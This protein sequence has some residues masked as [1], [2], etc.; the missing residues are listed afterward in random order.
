MSAGRFSPAIAVAAALLLGSVA[1]AQASDIR[2]E[3]VQFAAGSTGTSIEGS[4]S[5]Y[6]IVDYRLG[7]QSG[8][9][10]V[11]T[12][13]TDSGAN[14]FNLMAPGETEVAFFNGSMGEN[15]FVGSL[16]DSGDY[17]IRVYQMR[18]AAR[19]NETASYT[20]QIEI[21]S[22][23]S[24]GASSGAVADATVPGTKYHATG[25]IPCARAAG[26]P[27]GQCEF[28]VIREGQ[29]SGTL[30]VSWPE[31]GK[32]VIFYE[33]GTPMSFDSSEADGGVEMAVGKESDL[34]QVRIGEER[35]EIPD[36]VFLGDNP[37]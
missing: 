28:G 24:A 35:F 29:G 7:A 36:V 21:T 4:I 22:P 26:Q 1:F 25:S 31:G 10:M 12:M 17:T 14:Y 18:S 33:D 16:P 5:G 37:Y 8:Q 13:A 23:E 30:E 9:R 11:V 6:E 34:F 2:T 27:M 3:R 32:R 20:L 19:P 15:S